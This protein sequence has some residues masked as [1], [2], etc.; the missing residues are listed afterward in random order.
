MSATD[1]HDLRVKAQ[2]IREDISGMESKIR[3]I[4][5]AIETRRSRL[6]EIEQELNGGTRGAG[7][8]NRH[9]G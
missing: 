2:R 5:R 4:E 8:C 6:R 7:R 9:G 1:T 3:R